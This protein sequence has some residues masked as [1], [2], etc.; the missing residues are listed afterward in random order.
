VKTDQRQGFLGLASFLTQTSFPGRTS[1]TLRG[2][3]VLSELLCDPPPAPPANVPDLNASA[4]ADMNQ[5]SGSENVRVR[6]EKHRANPACAACH[7]ILDPMGLGLE[8]F[9]GIGRYRETYGNG[10]PI[11]P[12]GVLPDGTPFSGA[13]ELGALL[14]KDP[15]FSACVANQMFTYGLG[16]E[17]ENFDAPTMRSVTAGWAKRGLTFKNLMK[18]VVLSDAFRFRRGEPQ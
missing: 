16:R 8:R 5:P 17:I 15:R 7:Q 9:D 14:S 1:P 10:D 13:Q 2:V 3:W 18:E 11:V 4:P 12:D 6:L